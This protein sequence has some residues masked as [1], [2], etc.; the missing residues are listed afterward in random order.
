M[1]IYAKRNTDGE[2]VAISKAP[3]D[4]L[5]DGNSSSWMA[6]T[7]DAEEV[8]H[9]GAR[10]IGAGSILSESDLGFI[11]V[12]EDL[13]DLLLARSVIMFTDLPPA[14]QEKLIARRKARAGLHNL[15]LLDDERDEG[16]L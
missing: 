6:V 2:L 8:R 1:N 14:A 10:L 12:L 4:E 13:I 5:D 11:R 16:L 3:P 7:T 9:F 15:S